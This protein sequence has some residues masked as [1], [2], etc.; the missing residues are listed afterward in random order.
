MY[1]GAGD[2]VVL[3]DKNAHP[4]GGWNAGFTTQSGVSTVDGEGARR[5]MTVNQRH[6]RRRRA[7]R[8]SEWCLWAGDGG[9][10]RIALGTLTLNNSTVSGNAASGQGAGIYWNSGALTLNNSTVNGNKG[11][12]IDNDYG[13]VTVNYGSVSRQHVASAVPASTPIMAL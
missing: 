4:P 12:G 7:F 2:E 13:A 11:V 5:G 9:G 8:R 6:H 10:I 1:T 3:L